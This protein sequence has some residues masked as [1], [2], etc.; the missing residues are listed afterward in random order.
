MILIQGQ[1]VA[2][3]QSYRQDLSSGTMASLAA[4]GVVTAV[5]DLSVIGYDSSWKNCRSVMVSGLNLTTSASAN[6]KAWFSDAGSSND[7]AAM[8]PN[9]TANSGARSMSI[10]IPPMEC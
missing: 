3:S 7:Y 5:W 2:G 10:T 8:T 9:S 4:S 1:S 6:C